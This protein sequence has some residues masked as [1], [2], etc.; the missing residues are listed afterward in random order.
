[1]V[2]VRPTPGMVVRAGQHVSG[3]GRVYHP[4]LAQWGGVW[5]VSR[6]SDVIPAGTQSMSSE[7][8]S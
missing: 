2:Y 4:Y 8:E 5:D 3:E 1:M 7:H 6:M